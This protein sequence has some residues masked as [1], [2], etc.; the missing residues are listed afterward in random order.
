MA[1]VAAEEPTATEQKEEG[2]KKKRKAAEKAAAEP[3]ADVTRTTE[4]E[5]S[6]DG[7][8]RVDLDADVEDGSKT[9]E[10]REVDGGS[11]LVPWLIVIGAILLI[12][13]IGPFR[14]HLLRLV[15]RS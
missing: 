6:G 15:R 4:T 9:A 8:G 10:R 14:H 13:A 11:N 7:G 3:V 1:A 2:K 12:A 5:A